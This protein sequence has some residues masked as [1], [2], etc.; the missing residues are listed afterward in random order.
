MAAAAHTLS[1][2]IPS[3]AGLTVVFC[4]LRFVLLVY[5]SRSVIQS[6]FLQ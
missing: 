5:D 3:L 6:E 2:G 1:I 4:L